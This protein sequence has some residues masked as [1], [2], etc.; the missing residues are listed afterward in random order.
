MISAYDK[1]VAKYSKCNV[2]KKELQLFTLHH[3]SFYSNQDD[4]EQWE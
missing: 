1:S 4:L 2:L 3:F